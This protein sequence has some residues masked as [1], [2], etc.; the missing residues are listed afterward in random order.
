[1]TA[2]DLIKKWRLRRV[3][4]VRIEGQKLIID[5]DE[6]PDKL[7]ECIYAFLIGDKVRVGSS[8]ALL[9]D[10]LKNY[11]RHFNRRFKGENSPTTEQEAEQWR[12]LLPAGTSGVIY[13]RQ[14]TKFNS[15][16]GMRPA[17]M[18]EES[19]LIGEFSKLLPGQIINRCK[20]R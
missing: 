5:K 20:Y 18:D 17:Y 9:K 3:A 6:I 19:L 12:E 14:G 7:K 13:A 10:R 11:E 16:L 1:M 15:P 4:R 2:E 8:K